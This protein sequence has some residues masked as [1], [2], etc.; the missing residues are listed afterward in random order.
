MEPFTTLDVVRYNDIVKFYDKSDSAHGIISEAL[1]NNIVSKFKDQEA[2][3]A[4][5]YFGEWLHTGFSLKYNTSQFHNMKIDIPFKIV[6][7]P[8]QE[9]EYIWFRDTFQSHLVHSNV[10][11]W[12][13]G[14][15]QVRIL[16]NATALS[17]VFV[18]IM[19]QKFGY[20]ENLMCVLDDYVKRLNP[21]L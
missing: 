16:S 12:F 10:F 18:D 15:F 1:I 3:D 9:N 5:K 4:F 14:G 13:C 6:Q 17:I 8:W 21:P 20:D 11:T 19:R 7:G 2:K